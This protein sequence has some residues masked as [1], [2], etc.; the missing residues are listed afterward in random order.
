MTKNEETKKYIDK[1][2]E[3][4][5]ELF[6]DLIYDH[7]DNEGRYQLNDLVSGFR[8]LL[9]YAREWQESQ[10]SGPTAAEAVDVLPEG[11]STHRKTWD[12]KGGRNAGD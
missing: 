6:N 9:K 4:L 12:E 7:C 8:I 3:E 2:E 10:K 11:K 1:A 5:K